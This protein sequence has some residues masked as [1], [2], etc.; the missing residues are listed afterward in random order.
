MA[1]QNEQNKEFWRWK[2]YSWHDQAIDWQKA[3]VITCGVDVGSVSSQCVIMC[4]GKLYS[5]ASMRTGANSLNSALKTLDQALAGTG[6]TK[7]NID[8]TV[9]TGYGR[10]NIPFADKAIT[11]ISCNARGALFMYGP[12]VRTI[13]DM[14]GQDCK[15]I[16]VD[17]NGKVLSFVMN[18]KCAAGTGRGL[19]AFAELLEIPIQELGARSLV[20]EEPEPLNNTCVVFAKSEAIR[21]LRSGWSKE[22]VLAAYCAAM[23]QRIIALLKRGG[24]HQDFVITGGIA[25][26][27]GI[28]SRLKKGLGLTALKT[29][30]D[31]QLAGA[32]GAALFA[33]SLASGPLNEQ[34]QSKLY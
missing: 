29:A 25:K 32:I 28:V 14:G 26:N 9:G 31:T 20:A 1:E 24:I 2:E 17:E 7:D 12:T 16:N 4:D 23:A 5:L 8:F 34:R 22:K 11:E 33:L 13:L 3:S 19:E 27:I 30:Y 15:V 6:M 21:L 10:V 18:D